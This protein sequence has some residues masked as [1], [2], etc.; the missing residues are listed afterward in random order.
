ML[1]TIRRYSLPLGILVL[2]WLPASQ[3][4]TDD[5][6]LC[7]PFKDGKV[8]TSLVSS[9]L[10]A[11]EDGYLYRIRTDSSQVGFCVDSEFKR[12]EAAFNDFKG[13]V[14]LTPAD[15]V[16]RDQQA[17]VVIRTAS[18]DTR[19]SVIENLIKS[20]RFFDV[21][22]YPEIL[23]VSRHFE[24]LSADK[25]KIHGDLT[26]HGVTRPVAL[27]VSLIPE[28]QQ[29]NA[30]EESILIKASTVINRADFGMDSLSRL[31]SNQVELCM[32]VEVV[33]Y[34]QLTGS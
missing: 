2:G 12:V 10:E 33:R 32:T 11:A 1:K 9:M 18:L 23:F 16:K 15:W 29:Q 24:W 5:T 27:D 26:V 14:S 22:K 17:M 19:G 8:D 4:S 30:G 31:V 7:A 25:A 13:G 21:E 20:E 34:K 6:D 3:A 28:K